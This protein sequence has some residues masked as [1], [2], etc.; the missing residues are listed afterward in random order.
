MVGR[1]LQMA[2]FQTDVVDQFVDH[3]V[4]NHTPFAESDEDEWEF[5]GHPLGE[6][7]MTFGLELMDGVLEEEFYVGESTV[8]RAVRRDTDNRGLDKIVKA[9]EELSQHS[10]RTHYENGR[11]WKLVL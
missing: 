11:V 10:A 2:V 6:A 1:H 5:K 9:A 7:E 3:L 8:P 4:Q